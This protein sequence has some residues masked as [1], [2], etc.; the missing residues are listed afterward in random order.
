[1]WVVTGEPA[2]VTWR[3]VKVE[4]LDDDSARIAGDGALKPGERVVTSGAQKLM[5]GAPIQ[6][7]E[8]STEKSQGAA[9][10]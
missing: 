9:P 1:M 4:H 7:A 6:N 2:K 5:D 3:P 8:G 10:R